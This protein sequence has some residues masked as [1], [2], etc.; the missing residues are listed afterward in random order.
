MKRRL[1]IILLAL[2]LAVVGT[3]GV[4]EYVKRANARALAGL[5]P[6]SVLVAQR[7]IPSGT[8]PAVALRDGALAS[9]SLPTSAVPASAMSS[10]PAALAP[11]VLSAAL[12]PGQLL[13]RQ[14]LVAPAQL[15]SGLAIPP[16]LMAVTINFCLSE[17]VARA[18]HP[19]SYVAVFDTI[20]S[21][22]VSGQPGC[23]GSHVQV[24]GSTKTRMVMTRVLVLS[25][26]TSSAPGATGSPATTALGSS[27][28]SSSSGGT[29]TL[30][31]VAVTQA[32]A[33]RLIQL[34]EAGL[35]YLAL[36]TPASRT[37]ADVGSL[38]NAQPKPSVKPRPT[39]K[40]PVVTPSP[41]ASLQVPT[42]S[43]SP[44]KK[45]RQR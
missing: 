39:L 32:N 16:G 5:R 7:K 35:P 6:V 11:L 43:P 27:G 34:T 1:L 20:S 42:P 44:T 18:L 13:L 33:E 23:S 45:K 25:V 17:V 19:G 28:S 38:L 8:S 9:E 31:T 37:T 30:V 3:T 22:Q 40:F 12:Q 15:T 2:I 36:V 24:S 14:M 4:L 41:V 26:G 29:G 21:A 10:V